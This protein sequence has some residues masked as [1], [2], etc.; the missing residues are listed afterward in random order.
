MC[1]LAELLHVLLADP[2][3]HRFDPAA[4]GQRDTDLAQALG[5]RGRDGEYGLCLALGLV[6]LL[7]LIGFGLLDHPLLVALGRIDLR[8]ALAL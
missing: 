6:D 3:L 8:I 5:G 2:Q 4:V 1:E 7:L